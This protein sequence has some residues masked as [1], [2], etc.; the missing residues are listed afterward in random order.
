MGTDAIDQQVR[1]R[2]A[3]EE[4]L[5]QY[6]RGVD[7][8]DVALI[9][10][11]YFED[12]LDDH[13]VFKGKGSEFAERVV[14]GM[15]NTMLATMHN[16]HQ[17]NI[18]FEGETAYTE[19]YFTAHHRRLEDGATLLDT[20][21]GRYVDRFEK[22]SGIWKIA[23]RTVVYEWSKVETPDR[24]YDA[25]MFEHGKRSEKDLSYRD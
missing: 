21:G 11:V 3:I 19:A 5:R 9:R 25:S 8:G 14:E 10:A 20:F 1:D 15:R 13:G 4:V 24:E 16:L 6:C 12:A 23:Q 17:V 2:Y 18:R 22:R 7:R